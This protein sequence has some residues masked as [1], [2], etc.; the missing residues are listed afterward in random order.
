MAAA[1]LS[2]KRNGSHG[3]QALEPPRG[4]E[5]QVW[6]LHRRQP[7]P[8]SLAGRLPGTQCCCPGDRCPSLHPDTQPW[9]QQWKL[10][11]TP[12]PRGLI[13][14]SWD[15]GL[16][17]EHLLGLSWPPGRRCLVSAEAAKL[18]DGSLELRVTSLP[19][20]GRACLRM[21]PTQRESRA[22]GWRGSILLIL[23]EPLDVAMPEAILS[24]CKGEPCPLQGAQSPYVE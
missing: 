23:Q 3:N 5:R 11:P 20:P 7:S 10:L 18:V 17:E 6:G 15:L 22:G 16:A 8:M 2:R 21:P 12:C 9:A 24:V 14:S 1:G 19:P 13:P 4:P